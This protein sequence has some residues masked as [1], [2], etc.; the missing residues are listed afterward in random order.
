MTKSN[1]FGAAM[2]CLALAVVL[3]ALHSLSG[4]TQSGVAPQ[5]GASATTPIP[6]PVSSA[7]GAAEKAC[8]AY[9]WPH[10]G[11]MPQ[12]GMDGIVAT[13]RKSVCAKRPILTQPVGD[14][15]H[16]ALAI[17]HQPPTLPNLYAILMSSA[18]MESGGRFCIGRDTTASSP[19]ATSAES[20]ILQQSYD[21]MG[22]DPSLKAIY[23]EYQAHPERCGLDAFKTGVTCKDPGIYGTGS[24]ADFQA[25]LRKCPALAVEQAALGHRV[26]VRHW[27]PARRGELTVNP[28]CVTWLGEV[29]KEPCP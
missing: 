5:P 22:N 15:N 24:G 9:A 12:G 27:G 18:S 3:V 17:Y 28:D 13:F 16:D 26:A 23:L 7:P 14:A 10:R 19:S 2:L 29:A 1:S 21:L 20:G 8:R 6:A 4:C 11:V 25:F